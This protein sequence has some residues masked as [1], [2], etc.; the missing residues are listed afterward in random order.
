MSA[1]SPIFKGLPPGSLTEIPGS[2]ELS[3]A[4]AV[5]YS[6]AFSG[7]YAD[8]IAYALAHPKG[9]QWYLT[10][11]NTAGSFYVQS[12]KCSHERGGKGIVTTEYTYLGSLPPDEWSLTPFEI[13]PAVE[14]NAYFADLESAD[15]EK[16]RAAHNANTAAGATSVKSAIAGITNAALVT[17]LLAK[18]GR[19]E[20]SYYLAGYTFTHTLHMAS[21]PAA[22]KGGFI[23]QPFG[24]F[25]G[26]VSGAGLSW[27][28]KA[29]EVCWQNGIWKL[30]RSWLGAPEGHWDTDL[31]PA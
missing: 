8:C 25:S 30:T 22:S 14:T 9:S 19:G 4:D 31:Y 26:Y 13:N 3:L 20:E 2:G 12:T 6:Q 10:I 21:P 28:R 16:A 24:A 11:G 23:Q 1:N 17:S 7:R 29:D 5:T 15:L 18:W 27:L